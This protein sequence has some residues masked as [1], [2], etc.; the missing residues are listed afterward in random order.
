VD[1]IG[2][3]RRHVRETFGAHTDPDTLSRAELVVSEL[4]TNSVRHGPG[5]PITLRLSAHEDGGVAGELE[6]QGTGVVALR[7]Y[8]PG[9]VGGLGLTVVDHVASAWGVHPDSTHVWFRL[10]P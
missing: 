8:T 4:V 6:D 9:T 2:N 7:K 10:D 5:Q 1:S 3:A